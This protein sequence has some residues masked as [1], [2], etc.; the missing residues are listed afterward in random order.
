MGLS[1]IW[2]FQRF[3]NYRI[4]LSKISVV[5]YIYLS[6]ATI[7]KIKINEMIMK[8]NPTQTKI[9]EVFSALT[10]LK[11]KTPPPTAISKISMPEIT[12]SNPMFSVNGV[13]TPETR[14]A[15]AIM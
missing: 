13:N 7:V 15:A 5:S 8:D 10:P 14:A 11:I 12:F 6:A 3:L 1:M 9:V 4:V 2:L